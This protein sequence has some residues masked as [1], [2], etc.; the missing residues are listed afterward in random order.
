MDVSENFGTPKSSILAGFFHYKPPILGYPYFWKHPYSYLYLPGLEEVLNTTP[1]L[2]TPP[3]L[4]GGC[5]KCRQQNTWP[6]ARFFCC[7]FLG[8]IF[9]EW[10]LMGFPIYWL[11]GGFKYFLFSPLFGEDEP[12]L[13]LIFF[14]W[15]G[16]TT[17]RIKFWGMFRSLPKPWEVNSCLL[18][19]WRF[20]RIAF[21]LF[22]LWQTLGTNS[23]CFQN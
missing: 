23:G 21:S 13:T 11:G 6:G 15:V 3:G 22:F 9:G 14:N 19:L 4:H 20:W 8:G 7:R 12:I 1:S 16:S 2:M 17:N 10:S 5:H 18:T